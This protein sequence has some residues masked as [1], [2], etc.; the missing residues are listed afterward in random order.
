MA[1]PA[2]GPPWKGLSPGWI[3][4][5]FRPGN[6]AQGFLSSSLF[7][8]GDKKLEVTRIARE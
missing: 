2:N 3:G 1:L 8:A 6:V 5:P 7:A 4:H